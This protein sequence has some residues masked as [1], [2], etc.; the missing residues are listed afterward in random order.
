MGKTPL[1]NIINHKI[2]LLK[3]EMNQDKQN[4]NTLYNFTQQNT[5]DNPNTS[6]IP[7]NFFTNAN[8]LI[9]KFRK[10][11]SKKSANFDKITNI[12]LNNLPIRYIYYYT[13]LFNN[14]LNS[15]YFPS[16]WKT[17]KLITIKKE[18]KTEAIHSAT[19]R[20]VFSQILAKF[21]K[22]LLMTQ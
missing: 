5:S 7:E 6:L 16:S 21:L 8:K 11:K 20:L 3:Q 9:S 2:N 1:T 14:C 10:L 4:N 12:V 13:I 19:D 17:A 18:I 22:Q 15:S